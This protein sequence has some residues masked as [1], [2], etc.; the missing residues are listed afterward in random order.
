MSE[1]SIHVKTD[2]ENGY[3]I[4]FD[5]SFGSLGTRLIAAGYKGKRLCIISD[6]NVFPLYGE[7]LMQSLE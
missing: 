3:D 5:N 1:D 2:N 4:V 7:E 6:S